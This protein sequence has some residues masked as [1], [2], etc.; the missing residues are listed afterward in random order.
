MGND[1]PTT[2]QSSLAYFIKR[3]IY[4]E[5]NARKNDFCQIHKTHQL[6]T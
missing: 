6:T 2:L 3:M 1:L 5:P 4:Q